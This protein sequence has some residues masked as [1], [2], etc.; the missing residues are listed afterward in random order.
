MPPKKKQTKAIEPRTAILKQVFNRIEFQTSETD[1]QTSEIDLEL[2]ICFEKLNSLKESPDKKYKL[3]KLN[4]IVFFKFF[5]KLICDFAQIRIIFF[6]IYIFRIEVCFSVQ[7]C[8][9]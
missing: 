3:I 5:T 9:N 8:R 4:F 2:S 1:T 7:N 6:L